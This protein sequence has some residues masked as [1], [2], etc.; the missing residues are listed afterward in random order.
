MAAGVILSQAATG[1]TMGG[2]ADQ[3]PWRWTADASSLLHGGVNSKSR[4]GP[5]K[6]SKRRR[7]GQIRPRQD[8]GDASAH[9]DGSSTVRPKLPMSSF[10]PDGVSP[11]QIHSM[12]ASRGRRRQRA[13][14][15]KMRLPI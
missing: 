6:P 3:R 7:D 12:R 10:K 2:E 1:T 11:D 5:K 8:P 14:R 9:P 4:S 13:A 15:G